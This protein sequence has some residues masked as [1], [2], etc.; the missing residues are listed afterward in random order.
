MPTRTNTLAKLRATEIE[1]QQLVGMVPDKTK[2]IIKERL[3]VIQAEIEA[4]EK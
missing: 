4:A 2:A 3:K 1:L